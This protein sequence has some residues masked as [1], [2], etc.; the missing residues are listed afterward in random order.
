MRGHRRG[1]PSLAFKAFD[2]EM[3]LRL[4]QLVALLRIS[5]IL[6]RSHDARESPEFQA[7]CTKNALSLEF[8]ANWLAGHP[9]SAREL[10]IE[11][12]QLEEAGIEMS[13]VDA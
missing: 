9:L 7:A 8:E 11:A 6:E 10:V 12:A 13:F 2:P 5:V 1:L 4:T 3:A